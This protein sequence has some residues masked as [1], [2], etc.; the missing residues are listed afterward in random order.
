MIPVFFRALGVGAVVVLAG[1]FDQVH[2]QEE[3]L[4][5]NPPM[6]QVFPFDAKPDGLR[7]K[8]PVLLNTRTILG[9]DALLRFIYLDTTAAA[10]PRGGGGGGR[11]GGGHG[12]G[13]GHGHHHGNE[14]SSGGD[15]A[16]P[17]PGAGMGDGD[18]KPNADAT[19]GRDHNDS[20]QEIRT[21]IWTQPDLFRQALD[22]A[23]DIGTTFVYSLP[24]QTQPLRAAL[25]LPEGMFLGE[26]NGHVKV[27]ST[28]PDS[29]ALQS[30]VRPDDLILSFEEKIKVVTLHDFVRGYFAIKEETRTT[31]RP[32]YSLQ[33]WRPAEG[34]TIS[35][36]V[37][38]PPS[39]QSFFPSP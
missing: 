29:R 18:A 12:G 21:E 30:G 38:A 25:D 39:L 35:L 27:L 28:T 32:S 2:A 20:A 6:S 33:V 22:E 24:H 19:E 37:T 34:K 1:R 11:E 36:T 17:S 3:R 31:G 26:V 23:A 5:L 15:D 14:S 10:S 4:V 8:F 16:G 7:L 9:P 13:G